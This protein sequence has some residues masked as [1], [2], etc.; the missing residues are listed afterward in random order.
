MK[1]SLK[2]MVCI[3][4]IVF[5]CFIINPLYAQSKD[6]YIKG[7]VI[8]AETS[9]PIQ[10]AT[11]FLSFTTK[12]CLTNEA[13]EFSIMQIE[14]GN[15]EIVCAAVGY[16]KVTKK[17]KFQ[18]GKTVS[19]DFLLKAT[20]I[21]VN[22]VS[23]NATYP[24]EWRK[25]YQKFRKEFLGESSRSEF[26]EI[27]NPEII[28]FNIDGKELVASTRK[29]IY[30]LNKNL[31]YKITLYLKEFAWDQTYDKGRFAYD[32]F[33]EE[34]NSNDPKEMSSWIEN[35]KEA[36]LGSYRHFLISCANSTLYE[37][38]YRIFLTEKDKYSKQDFN[39]LKFMIRSQ[40]KDGLE[41]LLSRIFKKISLNQN[42]F[43]TDSTMEVFYTNRHEDPN[44]QWYK[45]RVFGTKEL[46]GFQSS[47]LTFIMRRLT[48]DD[49][50]KSID[51][52]WFNT[53][54][55]GYWAWK[56]VSDLLPD[57]YE[58]PKDSE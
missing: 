31:G 13:G 44:Y 32:P 45:E 49:K 22:E 56:R 30:I 42:R 39:K 6:T 14:P 15:F 52:D 40:T 34:L 28:D 8:D 33:F 9:E 27:T 7:K 36:Y 2:C 57:D 38:G 25:R 47:Y 37:D 16:S 26:C 11:V 58:P 53:I 51:G 24:G 20:P 3:F 43:M 19:C 55:F 29:P 18:K 48:F 1:Q 10:Y 54:L 4:S 35:R 17:I 5:Y 12:G 21:E 50:G 46:F 23:I 41:E